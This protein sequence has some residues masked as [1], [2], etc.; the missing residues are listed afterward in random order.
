MT[1]SSDILV[2]GYPGAGKTTF[3]AALWHLLSTEEYPSELVLEVLQPDRTH[4]NAIAKLWRECKEI[5]RTKLSKERTVTMNL[6]NRRNG[7]TFKI[8]LPDSSGEGFRR[9]FESR[10]WSPGFAKLVTESGRLLFFIHPGFLKG[11]HLIDQDVEAA[12]EVA[13]QHMVAAGNEPR[14]EEL[15]S[16]EVQDH[17]KGKSDSASENKPWSRDLAS[18][19]AKL[20]DLM[21]LIRN[22]T[23]ARLLRA[24]IIIS[25]WDVVGCENLTPKRWLRERIPLLWQYLESGCHICDYKVFG[26]SAQ[27]ADLIEA[28]SLLENIRPSQRIKVV[29]GEVSSHDITIPLQWILE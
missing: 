23:A 26:V 3:I 19:Q 5:E 1:K 24:T 22:A 9:T 15:K 17:T 18:P 10:R 2:V 13:K 27:G 21:Q 7:A 8:A 25:A 20:V 14:N 28:K 6:K 29:D 12:A 11:A 4:L 16:Q